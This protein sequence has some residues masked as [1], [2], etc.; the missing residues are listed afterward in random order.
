MSIKAL[1]S[2]L[3]GTLI[4]PDGNLV[5]GCAEALTEIKRLGLHLVVISNSS[6]RIVDNKVGL[7]PY[8]PDLVLTPSDIGIRKGSPRWLDAVCGF[9]KIERNETV[10]MGDGQF[11]MFTAANSKVIFFNAEWSNPGYKYGIPVRTPAMLSPLI[12]NFLMK[13]DLWYWEVN[14]FD[15]NGNEI[16]AKAL[17]G[18]RDIGIPGFKT[19]L[20]DFTKRGIDRDIGFISMSEFIIY[21]LLGSLYLGGTYSQIDTL[22][23]APGHTGGHNIIMDQS[24]HRF[25]RLFKDNF[26]PDILHRHTAS[27]KLAF[28]RAAGRVTTFQDQIQTVCLNCDAKTAKKMIVNKTIL[29]VDDFITQG[30]T[31]DW[32]RHLF[33]NAGATKVMTITVGAFHDALDIQTI[34]GEGKWDSFKPVSIN[35]KYISSKEISATFNQKAVEEIVNSYSAF[36]S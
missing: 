1:I 12:E 8:A 30:F 24:M 35:E 6:H 23:I 20:F 18:K 11:D 4:S 16:V 26:G 17:I 9:F 21:H 36:I 14:D 28:A 10:L 15:D 29:V 7:L 31:T 22:V 19:N 3:D 5:P 25:A 32:A 34:T 13:K 33:L 27:K 2:D